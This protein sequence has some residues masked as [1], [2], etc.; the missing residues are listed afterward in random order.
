[1]PKRA[2][3]SVLTLSICL[4]FLIPETIGQTS[5]DARLNRAFSAINDLK[6]GVLIVRLPS[7]ANKIAEIN[8]ILSSKTLDQA[9]RRR[10]NKILDSTIAER[11][12]Y[13]LEIINSFRSFYDFS[14]Y[15]FMLDTATTHLNK[16]V[17]EGIFY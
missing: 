4:L 7:K 11:D 9:D 2:Y 17:R 10:M 12:T 13:N 16:G 3:Q 6:E 5:T 14:A 1:M 15:R 8:K